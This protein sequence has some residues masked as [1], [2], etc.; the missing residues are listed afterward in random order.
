MDWGSD[1]SV[2][3][4]CV[5]EYNYISQWTVNMDIRVRLSMS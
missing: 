4:Q 2:T 5:R 1:T 3:Y